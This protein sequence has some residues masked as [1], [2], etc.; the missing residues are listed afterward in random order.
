MLLLWN[1]AYVLDEIE[2]WFSL[3]LGGNNYTKERISDLKFK[4]IY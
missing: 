1:D 4:T 3:L 2:G